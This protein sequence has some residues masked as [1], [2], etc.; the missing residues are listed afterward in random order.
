[1]TIVTAYLDVSL[2]PILQENA[3]VP[4]LYYNLICRKM[5]AKVLQDPHCLMFDAFWFPVHFKCV[6]MYIYDSYTVILCANGPRN[7]RIQSTPI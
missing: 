7:Q 5:Q 4:S 1:M 3:D 2:Y 6:C